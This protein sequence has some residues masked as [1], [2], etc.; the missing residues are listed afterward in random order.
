VSEGTYAV[1]ATQDCTKADGS[2]APQGTARAALR[3][4]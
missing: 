3:I 1:T 4:S 2:D